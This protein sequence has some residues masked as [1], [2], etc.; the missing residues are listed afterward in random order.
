MLCTHAV[1]ALKHK[2]LV[3]KQAWSCTFVLNEI[4]DTLE[5]HPVRKGG[6]AFNG[7]YGLVAVCLF[8][9]ATV[10]YGSIGDEALNVSWFLDAFTS[11]K[12]L[13]I[14]AN[15]VRCSFFTMLTT[16]TQPSRRPLC[17]RLSLVTTSISCR[18]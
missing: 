9:I 4:V 15:L 17:C 16:N 12:W 13:L 8:T 14:V 2:H 1:A 6:K 3:H 5:S 11:P 10:T 18:F 7:A